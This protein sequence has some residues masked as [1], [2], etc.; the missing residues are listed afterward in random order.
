LKAGA[1]GTDVNEPVHTADLASLG[2]GLRQL[3]V[4][5]VKGGVGAVQ[6][7]NQV[8]HHIMGGHAMAQE[9]GVVHIAFKHL[10]S[11]Q[12]L[13]GTGLPGTPRDHGHAAAQTGKLFTH[14]ATYKAGAAQN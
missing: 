3:H 7:G 1:Q 13:N 9:V 6:Y 5:F 4:G 10:H 8:D 2:N 12:I 11:G 14:M